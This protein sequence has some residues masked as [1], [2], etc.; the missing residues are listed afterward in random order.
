[1]SD[2][3]IPRLHSERGPST[4]HR[5]RP[6]PGSV[7]KSR[8]LPNEAGIEA[9]Y[10]TVFHEFAA[11]CLELGVDPYIFVGAT[12]TVD[13]HGK[14]EFDMEMAD[15][16]L[17]G[18]DYFRSFDHPGVE[19]LVEKQV[20]LHEWVGEGEFGTS[21]VTVLDGELRR[22]LVGDWKYGQ[23]V[24]VS[25]VENDQAI[26]YGLGAWTAYGRD[27]FGSPDD[28]EVII[29]IEQPRAPGGGGVWKT[30]MKSMIRTGEQIKRDADRTMEPDAPLVPGEKQ[31]KFCLAAKFNICE[32][33]TEWL[34]EN[35]GVDYDEIDNAD[36]WTPLEVGKKALTP[37]QRT[38]V[39][40]TAPLIRGWLDQLHSEAYHDLQHGR[41]A[42]GLRLVP[43]RRPARVW[44]DPD[45]A[46]EI[47][48][49]RLGPKQALKE[50]QIISPADLQS[51]VGL[52]TYREQFARM[53]DQG[54]PKPI[55]AQ[56]DDP[57]ES[58]A[59][60]TSDFPEPDEDNI[61]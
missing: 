43:G 28:V 1:M 27:F 4:A 33:R 60:L 54:D 22:M 47:L 61:I 10:G 48:K 24:P 56:E 38:R 31:C 49:T 12:S 39:L 11:Y 45:K 29:A 59:D 16:M 52:G 19:F 40:N 17:N 21:D 36:V 6:C 20:P 57:R 25:P 44:K 7:L 23:G 51:L 3:E 14:V 46:L 37:E 8:G 13:Q 32:A 15:N 55:I 26:L 18:L 42:P 41:P 35:A 30:D 53:V 2:D 5:W 9:A 50:P 58:F 34:L